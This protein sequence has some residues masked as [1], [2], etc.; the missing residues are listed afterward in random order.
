MLDAHGRTIEDVRLSVT[1]R[2]NLRCAYCLDPGAR[3]LGRSELLS[4]EEIV[5][6]ARVAAS[7]GARRVRL[8][9]GEPTLHPALPEIIR[10]LVDEAGVEAS[11]ITN[12]TLADERSLR[13]WRKAGLSRITF[14]LDTLRDDR[15]PAIARAPGS[16]RRVVEAIRRACDV[17]LRP[18]KVNA[19]LLRGVNDD[20]ATDFAAL[21]REL[22]IDMRFIEFMPLDAGRGWSHD[23]LVPA[24]ETKERIERRFAIVEEAR[25]RPSEVASTCRFADGAPGRV[26]FVASVTSPFCGACSRLRITADGMIRP[27]LFGE[28]E[29]DLRDLMR[30]GASDDDIARRLVDAAWTK[31]R[32]HS[33]GAEDFRRPLRSMSAIGG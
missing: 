4:P 26:G 27:C 14:S 1:D 30:A 24:A 32:G 33:I 17:G 19:V 8:T 23:R 10:G 31:V 21:A 16:P 29:W 22:G 3:F 20:E 18:V 9:G 7:V 12:G 11:L 2:C 13:R 6:A 25:A 28:R 5:R 15:W